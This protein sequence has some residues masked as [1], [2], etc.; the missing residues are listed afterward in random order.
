VAK[1]L[2]PVL[3]CDWG[4]NWAPNLNLPKESNEIQ[5]YLIPLHL[6]LNESGHISAS[7]EGFHQV[8]KAQKVS[9]GG[10]HP[11]AS[12]YD[13][14]A[15]KVILCT[16]AIYRC[17]LSTYN[18]FPTPSEERELIKTAWNHA[19]EETL[20]DIPIVLTPVYSA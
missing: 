16:T 13:D 11:K 10:S 5:V 9:E 20:K 14:I 19:N 18:A 17:L 8:I 6:Y 12:V 7:E 4:C 2:T 15:K 3:H 1:I